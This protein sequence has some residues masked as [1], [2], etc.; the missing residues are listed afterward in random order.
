MPPLFDSVRGDPIQLYRSATA[1]NNV[2]EIRQLIKAGLPVDFDIYVDGV[3]NVW[4]PRTALS[5]ACEHRLQEAAECL[6]EHGANVC[7]HPEDRKGPLTRVIDDSNQDSLSHM[8]LIKTLIARG[9]NVDSANFWGTSNVSLAALYDF[10]EVLVTLIECGADIEA[11][12]SFGDRPVSAA[13]LNNHPKPLRILLDAGANTDP[14]QYSECR[15]RLPLFRA[16]QK[17]IERGQE[18]INELLE[19]RGDLSMFDGLEGHRDYHEALVTLLNAYALLE[20]D[21]LGRCAA[22][23]SVNRSPAAA[24]Y[25][26]IQ[27]TAVAMRRARVLRRIDVGKA[28][29][30][31]QLAT[32]LQ[33]GGAAV[34]SPI[35]SDTTGYGHMGVIRVTASKEVNLDRYVDAHCEECL[36][37]AQRIDAKIFFAQPVIR[38]YIERTFNGEL[39]EEVFEHHKPTIWAAIVQYLTVTALFI[40]QLPLLPVIALIPGL[41]R[42]LSERRFNFLKYAN[43]KCEQPYILASPKVRFVCSGLSDL[44]LALIFMMITL[45]GFLG[46]PPAMRATL[47]GMVGSMVY[48]ELRQLLVGSSGTL[49]YTH[50]QAYFA[51]PFNRLDLP[52]LVLA[53]SALL[54]PAANGDTSTLPDLLGLTS[55]LL[56][57]RLLRMLVLIPSMGPLVLMVFVMV[58][59][60]FK[61]G[62]LLMIVVLSFAAG[63]T[64]WFQVGLEPSADGL[65]DPFT[66]GVEGS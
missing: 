49:S 19:K 35:H 54:L 14:D 62:V 59:D 5:L 38:G 55:I 4:Y 44:A 53:L 45:P 51:D 42:C 25:G 22:R 66:V 48:W 37:L 6:I 3:D 11:A 26:C 43:I 30:H 57:L 31:A 18:M 1:N 12:N 10:S 7:G 32:R 20:P 8:K 2:E 34:L 60:L 56:C 65:C 28:D 29:Q 46:L 16:C 61:W 41:G 33:L 21:T 13:A 58:N 39:L 17:G 24:M 50:L 52:A 9:A 63:I 15:H 27:L 47:L 64:K 40:S 23:A 36:H